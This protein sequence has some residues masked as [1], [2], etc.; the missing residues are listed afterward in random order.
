MADIVLATLNARYSHASLALRCL[1]AALGRLRA[2]AEWVEFDIRQPV[3]RVADLLLA[4]QPRVVGVGVYIWNAEPVAELLAD[5]RARAPE[6]TRVAGGPELVADAADHPVAAL[7]D[8]VIAGEAENTLP[9]LCAELLAG[10]RPAAKFIPAAT[11]R[12]EDL[13]LP[14]DD[15]SAKDIAHRTLYVESS[16]GCP[17]HC[18]YCLSAG[19]APV[20]YFPL[21]PLL[22]AWER[23]IARGAR[24][25]K[26]V[27]RT[28]NLDLARCDAILQFFLERQAQGL[29]LHCEMIPDRFPPALRDRLAAFPPGAVQLEI[30][31]Q[32]WDPD[33]AR[34]VCRTQDST[35]TAASLQWLRDHTG[36]YL[37]T[38]LIAGLPGE[39]QASFAAGFDRLAALRPHEIQIEVLKRLRG[40]AITRFDSEWNMRYH[41]QPPYELLHHRTM[42]PEDLSAI[43]RFARAWDLW[44]NSGNFVATA[45]R[46]WRNAPSTYQ[47]FSQ[48]S[49]WAFKRLGRQHALSLEQQA[50]TLFHYLVNEN[51]QPAN[52]VAADLIRDYRRAGRRETPAFLQAFPQP[53]D[54]RLP[55]P[56]PW[57]VILRRQLRHLA[58]GLPA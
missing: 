2:R 34:R 50:D 26:F 15:Y 17:F 11:P 42:S 44:V 56:R 8:Y 25:F 33:V 38:D 23:L 49:D 3:A 47:S 13:P 37:H 19:S 18:A 53:A 57:P 27:D 14:Y 5:L 24:Y 16:R 54:A 28:F 36:V 6:I 32:T 4:R 45:A 39:T 41:P 29:F 1:H 21:A 40:T 20:R 48:W 43:K 52:E 51:H 46:L 55:E 30:G 7:A 9:E 12:L 58:P 35:H 31:V 10:R 22:R